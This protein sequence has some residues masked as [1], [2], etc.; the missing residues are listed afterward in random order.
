MSSKEHR[1]SVFPSFLKMEGRC[2]VV[3]GNGPEALAKVRLLGESRISI[4]L[5]ALTPSSELLE[6]SKR[7]GIEHVAAPFASD[8]IKGAALV[9]A[10]TGDERTDLEIVAAAR[11]FGIPA[12]A[13]DRPSI[14]DFY[15]PALVNRAP[16]A[17]AIGSEGTGP[18]LTQM[19]RTQVEALLPRS[20]GALA[21][22]GALYRVA[23]DRLVPRGVARRRFWRAF[24]SGE[25]AQLVD[26]G[27]LASA[28]RTAT[29]LLKESR[30][31]PGFVTLVPTVSD[32]ADLLTLRAVRAL[33][34][35]DVV[36]HEADADKDLI[37]MGRRDA[38]RWA[39]D[40]NMSLSDLL[41]RI[42][43]DVST[44]KRFV[45]LAGENR[46]RASQMAAALEEAGIAFAIIPGVSA[47][48]APD[49]L[50]NLA[51]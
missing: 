51:A 21:R 8:L 12:N 19:I 39:V 6:H 45:L 37:A 3:M 4:R 38:D 41:G 16:I 42:S 7:S 20:T 32:A 44:G 31:E 5:V 29:R 9:F 30:A 28:R 43:Q 25:V 24:F 22:L 13:V 2:A 27:E 11:Q 23:V 40:A 48:I 49:F 34:E 47:A 17:V 15:T 26:R 1:L 36:V 46:I 14:C 50:A 18:V 33:L 35:A 10:A